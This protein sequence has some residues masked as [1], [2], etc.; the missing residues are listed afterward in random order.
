[1]L[2]FEKLSD[3]EQL[4]PT[5]PARLVIHE[6]LESL[7]RLTEQEGRPYRARI[8]GDICLAEPSDIG[9][10]FDQVLPGYTLETTPWEAVHMHREIWVAAYVPNNT[11]C[12]LVLIPN[13]D[14][15]PNSLRRVLCAN[16]VPNVT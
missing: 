13:K 7:L 6:I 10:T 3:L 4:S 11:A 9:R 16:L 8:D 15:L 5:N 2:T 12:T 14:W 1:M